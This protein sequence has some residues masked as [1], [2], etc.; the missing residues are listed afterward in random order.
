MKTLLPVAAGAA[1]GALLMYYLDARSGGR[2]RALA[3]DKLVAAGHDAGAFAQAKGKRAADKARGVL[4]TGRLD[5]RST[6]E[7]ESDEQLQG[8]IRSRLG[9][10][11]SHPKAVHVEVE[12]SRVALSG[13]L[14]AS[15]V[16][17]VLA[18]IRAMPGVKHIQNK[19][20]VHENAQGVP[21]LQG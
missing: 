8:R 10:L 1:A 5:R 2:R 11:L 9:R 15:E 3:R 13:H 6:S 20:D 16:D 21:E 19:L 7:P 18:E 12:G 4:A 14:L 17:A